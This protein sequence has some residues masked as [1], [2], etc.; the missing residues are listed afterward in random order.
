MSTPTP[1]PNEDDKH[2]NNEIVP[3]TPGNDKEE[4]KQ[5]NSH[6]VEAFDVLPLNRH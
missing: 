4:V 3:V 6:N 2:A 5:L 1:T